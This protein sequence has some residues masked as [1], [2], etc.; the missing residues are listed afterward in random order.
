MLASAPSEKD[1][2]QMLASL[3]QGLREQQANRISK[4]ERLPV[5]L[6]KQLTSLWKKDTTN[7]TLLRLLARLNF[8]PASDGQK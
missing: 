7:E 1:K 2:Q 3:E 4:M 5:N 6:Q 8:T